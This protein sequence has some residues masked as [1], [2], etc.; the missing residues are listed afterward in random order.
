MSGLIFPFKALI[1]ECEATKAYAGDFLD[2]TTTNL[3]DEAKGTLQS[4]QR[5]NAPKTI[6]QI[7]IDR[8][9]V[10]VWSD[11]ESKPGNG[12]AHKIRAKFSFAWEIHKLADARWRNGHFLL[13][14]LASTVTT[15][16]AESDDQEKVIARWTTDVGDHAS[17]GTHFHF[18]VNRPDS[19]EF[20]FPKSLDIP[21]LPGPVM[22]PFLAV[23]FALGELFQDRWK[24]HALAETQHTNRWRSLH[25]ERLVR[26]FNWQ[27]KRVKESVGSPWMALKIDKP[28]P[29][30]FV[31]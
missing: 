31:E 16:V 23:D 24:E 11:R 29:E 6:W 1:D 13:N 2:T 26:F 28:R 10:T 18:Q 22:S 12:S 14:G 7:P 8:P 3:L 25:Q 4:F 27:A 20:P 30:L 21:R 15:I 19:E 17:P 5:S 9:L